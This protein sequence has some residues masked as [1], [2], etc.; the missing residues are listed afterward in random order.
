M[1][2]P[3]F[4]INHG[5]PRFDLVDRVPASSPLPA[6]SLLLKPVPTIPFF[7]FFFSFFIKISPV[8]PSAR[9][10]GSESFLSYLL[11]E[12]IRIFTSAHH[13]STFRNLKKLSFSPLFTLLSFSLFVPN[14]S[15]ASRSIFSLFSD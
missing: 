10:L 14:V 5:D 12:L 4:T 8:H 13:P 7:F 9:P 3:I 1:A 2:F 6:P 15:Y 11:P